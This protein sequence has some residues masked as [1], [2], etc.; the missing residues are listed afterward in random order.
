MD[1]CRTGV[2]MGG[3]ADNNEFNRKIADEETI[4]KV[5]EILKMI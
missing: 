3:L 1:F 4:R 2:A 5:I